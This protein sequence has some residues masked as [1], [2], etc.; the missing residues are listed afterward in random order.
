LLYKRQRK[1]RYHLDCIRFGLHHEQYLVRLYGAVNN[2]LCAPFEVKCLLKASLV[3]K[4]VLSIRRGQ[5]HMKYNQFL[6]ERLPYNM[7]SGAVYDQCVI[8]TSA[9]TEP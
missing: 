6:Q 9:V 2:T 3:V 1:C 5:F 8:L 7:N 4:P